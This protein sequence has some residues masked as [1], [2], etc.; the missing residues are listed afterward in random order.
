A[1]Q[2]R[3]SRMPPSVRRLITSLL[4]VIT[5]TAAVAATAG[6]ALATTR[7]ATPLTEA[8]AQQVGTDA[9]T[10]GIALMEYLR[11]QQQNTSVTVPNKLGDAPV[12]QLGSDATLATPNNAAF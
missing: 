1:S 12:N 10:Y 2:Q 5:A 9:Y 6:P 7:P 11:Q 3:T 8:Q 4:G